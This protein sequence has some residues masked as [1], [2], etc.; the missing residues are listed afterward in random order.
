MVDMDAEIDVNKILGTGDLHIT[1]YCEEDNR[2]AGITI[3]DDVMDRLG[4]ANYMIYD[5]KLILTCTKPG[6]GV[7]KV[8]YI[9]GGSKYDPT[10]TPT[11]LLLEKELVIVSRESNDDMGWL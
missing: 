6:V 4:V 7:V 11:G 1:L 3:D 2:K 5:N 8:K 9:A 10:N